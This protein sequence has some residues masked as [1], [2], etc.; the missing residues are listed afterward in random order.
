LLK[1]ILI[2]I[3]L[4][5]LLSITFFLVSNSFNISFDIGDLSYSFSSNLLVI[6]LVVLIS[7]IILLNFIYFKTKFAFQKYSY[8]KKLTKTQK[9]YDFF[10][11]AMIA[12]LNKDNKSATTSARKMKGLLKQETSLNL[13]LQ[14]EILKIEKKS[15]QLNDV[16]DLMI[17]NNKTKTLGY[18]GLMEQSLKQQD[19]HHAFIYGEKLFL[20]NPKIEKLYDTLVNIIAKTRN[21]NQL[22]AMTD[23]AYANKIIKKEQAYENKS[24]ALYEIA[25][26]KMKSDVKES[27]NLIERAISLKKN[28]PPYIKLYLQI[29]FS[30]NN[31]NKIQK[32]LKKYW[33]EFPSAPL[34]SS[35]TE[36]LKEN[37]INEISF[38]KNFTAKNINN[39]ESK[40]LLIDF[41]IYLSEWSVARE[42]IKELIGPNPSRE[43]CLFMSE[44]E[45]GEF[46]DIQKS[47]GWKL[48]ANN[49]ELDNY[50]V[51]KITN[52]PQKDWSTLSESGHFNSLEWRQPKMLSV[53]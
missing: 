20:L 40:K 2:S 47:E 21:W 12:L 31:I 48:R 19:Y 35:I 30:I 51:C 15:D 1:F 41:A 46:N 37:N 7:I 9:G 13:L 38:I 4:I 8:V 17:K 28:F 3:Q 23:K 53:I 11:E 52:N 45:L 24:I 16:Y 32:V 10:V 29:L 42:N 6:S 33:N 25:K 44:I 49:A 27:I 14:S 36:V 5:L 18:R 50:W 43:I 39:E 22:T 34:R 26:I